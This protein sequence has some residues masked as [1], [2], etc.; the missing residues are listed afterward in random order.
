M[1]VSLLVA[2]S[3]DAIVLWGEMMQEMTLISQ[4]S[5][6]SWLTHVRSDSGCEK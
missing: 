3:D 2:A 1:D 5:V 4:V 6:T